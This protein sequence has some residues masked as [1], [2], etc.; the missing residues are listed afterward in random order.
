M[1][2]QRLPTRSMQ[3]SG[4]ER[5]AEPTA[6]IRLARQIREQQGAEQTRA[7]FLAMTPFV[8]PGELKHAASLF[9]IDLT[10]PAATAPIVPKASSS[11]PDPMKLM[12]AL[13]Q[14]NG[15]SKNGIDAM[16]L[17]E[18]MRGK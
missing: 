1:G 15:G 13:M 16:R 6:L 2:L 12:A 18:L 17:I 11:G 10:P 4:M 9:G 8:A 7:F 14:M 3:V 5:E